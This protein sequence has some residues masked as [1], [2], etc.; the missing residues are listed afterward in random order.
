V[1]LCC[2]FFLSQKTKKTKILFITVKPNT[3]TM[4]LFV[5]VV[6]AS[7]AM[8]SAFAPRMGKVAVS[9]LVS[10]VTG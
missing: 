4:Q 5:I 10:E 3:G 9:K 8:A 2:F 1:F 6:L 7:L